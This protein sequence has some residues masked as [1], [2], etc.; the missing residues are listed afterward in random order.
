M[1]A[2]YQYQAAKFHPLTTLD[3][4][5]L[6]SYSS[7]GLQTDIAARARKKSHIDIDENVLAIHRNALLYGQPLTLSRT[8]KL[9]TN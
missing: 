4:L 9:D 8:N 7:G 2:F 3:M 5:I 1:R 6:Q